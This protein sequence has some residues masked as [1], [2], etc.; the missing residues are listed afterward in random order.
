[1]DPNTPL[2]LAGASY[3][4]RAD[5][6]EAFDTIWGA[7]H[8]GE[9]DHMSVAVLTKDEQGQLQVDRHNSTAKH[10]AWG[11][12]ILTSALVVVAPPA[13]IAAV[14]AGGAAGASAGGLVGHF[15]H[16]IP[17]DKI[18]EVSDLLES[19]ESGLLIVAVNPKGTDITPLL[20]KAKRSTVVQTTAGDLDAAYADA[21]KSKTAAKDVPM[22]GYAADTTPPGPLP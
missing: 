20:G 8:E 5:A 11:S 12:A 14:A 19:G 1:M 9:F 21:L 2:T 13:G 18:R 10:L 4:S 15:W 22:Q 6:I 7:R 3:A 16:T 17:K